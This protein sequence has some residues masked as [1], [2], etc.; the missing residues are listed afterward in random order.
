MWSDVNAG[1]QCYHIHMQRHRFVAAASAALIVGLPFL[2][3][4]ALSFP[5]QS[6][7]LSR[8]DPT[9]GD[10]VTIYTVLANDTAVRS[11][12]AVEFVIDD[13]AV[14]TAS[15]DLRA[16]ESKIVSTEW[17][18]A[19]GTHT[20]R[21]RLPESGTAS[22]SVSVTVAARVPTR[23]E[24]ALGTATQ[25][26]NTAAPIVTETLSKVAASTENWRTAG[27][28]YLA[29]ALYDAT[30]TQA[31]P[32]AGKVLGVAIENPDQPEASQVSWWHVARTTVLRVLHAI[33]SSAAYFYPFF[34]L[35]LLF[36]LYLAKKALTR[37]ER[38]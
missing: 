18:A 31:G 32:T 4:A 37:G 36:G 34:A 6:L 25:V 11:T 30:T 26:A 1:R 35:L 15:V 21:A 20:V 38:F 17:A 5:A 9:A 13:A 16:G 3:S 28:R 22:P 23:I 8:T 27:E 10:T 29:D 12:T 33:F 2:A 19:E 7:W 14:H 24:A